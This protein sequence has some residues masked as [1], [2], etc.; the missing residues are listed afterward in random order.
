MIPSFPC[1]SSLIQRLFAT[2]L[3]D[4]CIFFFSSS[5]KSVCCEM[6]FLSPVQTPHILI[7]ML[8]LYV[9]KLFIYAPDV[10]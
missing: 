6:K 5:P 2:D 4:V 8:T 9:L 1:S 3:G 10:V 7:I